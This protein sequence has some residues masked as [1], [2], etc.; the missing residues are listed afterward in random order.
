M[1]KYILATALLCCALYA[2]AQPPVD[3][4]VTDGLVAYYPCNGAPEEATG[5]AYELYDND[6]FEGEDRFGNPGGAYWVAGDVL[7]TPPLPKDTISFW[8]KCADTATMSLISSG[9]PEMEF[10]AFELFVVKEGDMWGY[11]PKDDGYDF[12]AARFQGLLFYTGD[13]MEYMEGKVCQVAMPI[14]NLFDDEWHHLAIS[15]EGSSRL[16]VWY[17]GRLVD[18][19]ISTRKGSGALVPTYGTWSERKSSPFVLPGTLESEERPII[20]GETDVNNLD[21]AGLDRAQNFNGFIDD[22]RIYDRT[23]RRRDVEALFRADG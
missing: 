16:V 13:G 11:H 8:F 19:Y 23:L 7:E 18:G 6:A 20:I 12:N 1:R 9:D 22:I 21:R 5:N 4:V 15:G 2:F 17:D 14:R 3:P 10:G